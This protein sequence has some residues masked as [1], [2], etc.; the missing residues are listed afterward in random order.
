M[1]GNKTNIIY[2]MTDQHR[3]SAIGAYGETPCKTPNI[4]R[5]AKEGTLFQNAYTTFPVCSPARGSVMTGLYPHSHGITSNIHEIGC[6]VHELE[7][8]PSLLPRRLQAAGYKIGYT[9]KWHLGTNQTTTFQGSNEPSL[10]STIGF[11]GQDFPG[12]SGD[13]SGFPQY[14]EWL[15]KKGHTHRIKP[16]AEKTKKVRNDIGV[17]DLPSS[18]TVPAF[19]VENSIEMIDQ[20]N[21]TKNPFAI[22]LNFWGPHN[23]YHATQEYIDMY[24]DVEIPQWENYNWDSRGTTGPH[25]YKIHCNKEELEWD[26]WETAI[27]YYY[28]RTTMIDAQIGRLYEHLKQIGILENTAIVFTSDHGETLGSHG[29]LLDKGWHHFEETHRIPMII[30]MPN[31]E[32]QGIVNDKLVSLVDVYPTLLDIAKTEEK[33]ECH[34]ASLLPFTRVEE[35]PWRDSI[36]TEFL[37][38]GNV[39]TCMKTIRHNHLKYGYNLTFKDELYDLETD[40][41]EQKNLIDD[42]KY[43]GEYEKM[44]EKLEEWMIETSD[45]AL[46]TY[47]WGQR[48]LT[49]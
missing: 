21:L 22:F 47:K 42:P 27:R 7:D 24:Q 20:F 15:A 43:A 1:S 16:W 6:C 8:R 19:L 26:D 37:G 13:G 49:L 3:L 28:A 17:L 5:L 2:I 4:D 14:E 10:P 40:P 36:V 41:F 38:L 34:G 11:E 46:R 18:A 44:K 30:R 48:T 45:P 23:P 35:M 25:H 29:G 39:A 32:K 33:I 31:Q 9:G 12:H